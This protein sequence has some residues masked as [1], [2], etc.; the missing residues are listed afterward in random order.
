MNLP[1]DSPRKI[2]FH[3]DNEN[4][5]W[6]GSWFVN[7]LFNNPHL[8]IGMG[9]L[10]R[11]PRVLCLMQFGKNKKTKMKTHIEH[12][13]QPQLFAMYILTASV[14]LKRNSRKN[15]QMHLHNIYVKKCLG[16]F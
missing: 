10:L 11:F 6:N 7:A 3:G 15:A 12:S 16:H 4:L 13:L 2:I 1:N 14:I 5:Q 9:N 8:N